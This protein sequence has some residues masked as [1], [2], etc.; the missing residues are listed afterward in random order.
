MALLDAILK[1]GRFPPLL[2]AGPPGVGKRTAALLLARAANCETRPPLTS[3]EHKAPKPELKSG[4]RLL[5]ENSKSKSQ[6]LVSCGRCSSCRTITLLHHPDVR[7]F[8]PVRPEKRTADDEDEMAGALQKT[9]EASER[10]QLGKA[11]PE[12]DP[13]HTISIEVVRWL[14]Q[15][16]TK[17]PLLA[18]HRF[19]V[20]LHAHRMTAEAANAFL[21]TLEEPQ[22]QTALILT[23]DRPTLL[24]ETIRSRCRLVRFSPITPEKLQQWLTEKTGIKPEEAELAALVADGSPGRALRFLNEPDDFLAAPVLEFFSLPRASERD[25]LVTMTRLDQ[26]PLAT[27]TFTLLFLFR[28]ALL[29][30]LGI[31]TGY[32]RHNPAIRAKAAAS[33]LDY[34][35]QENL[36]LA[37]RLEDCRLNINRRLFLY[38]LLADV[39]RHGSD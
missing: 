23:T 26:T 30:K 5:A 14:R 2:F 3:A 11:Q 4:T 25:V 29:A 20:I 19:F 33:S 16:M 8:F 10:Y 34:L 24:F 9:L 12:P 35:H 32:A 27:V 22:R 39:R 13:K 18:R 6:S 37:S 36:F 38:T 7:V 17:P 28:Q 1:V 31:G 21:K 15:E